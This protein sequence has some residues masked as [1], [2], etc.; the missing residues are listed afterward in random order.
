MFAATDGHFLLTGAYDNTAK[1]W[2]HPGWM[3]LKTLAGHEGKVWALCSDWSIR[4]LLIAGDLWPVCVF[5]W[6]AS[7]CH[8]MG[9]SSP[10][11]PTIGPSNCGCLSDVISDI[12]SYVIQTLIYCFCF[13][14]KYFVFTFWN[15]KKNN[16]FS[17]V[18]SWFVFMSLERF[19]ISLL[20]LVCPVW[21]FISPV[22]DFTYLIDILTYFFRT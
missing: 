15:K 18:W 9:N 16:S 10:P 13:S 11:V 22:S 6:W 5:R 3:P 14:V 12:M 4:T 1:V 17:K 8:L 21:C 20:K 7:T 19:Y 2:S